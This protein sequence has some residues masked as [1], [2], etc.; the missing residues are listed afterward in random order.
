M[1]QKE[2]TP[3]NHFIFAA[4]IFFFYGLFSTSWAQWSKHAG[5]EYAGL[6]NSYSDAGG[7]EGAYDVS[8]DSAGNA[9]IVG[10]INSD[11]NIFGTNLVADGPWDSFVSKLDSSGNAVWTRH[12]YGS[13]Y[14]AKPSISIDHSSNVYVTGYFSGTA[15]IF[16]SSLTST[17]SYD[18]YLTKLDAS[19][20]AVWAKSF[21]GSNVEFPTAIVIDDSTN[22]YVTGSFA[23]SADFFGTT[24][25]STGSEDI[26]ISKLDSDG[27]EIWSKR[28][29]GPQLDRGHD[30]AVDSSGHVFI[31][32]FFST[33]ADVFG[34]TFV[35]GGPSGWYD[36]FVAQLD[37]NG[38]GVWAKQGGSDVDARDQA[39]GIDVD[40]NGNVY[41]IGRFQ[42]DAD[43][44]GET[45]SG[46][47][48]DNV[49]IVRLEPDGNIDW[50]KHWTNSSSTYGS[51]VQVSGTNVYVTGAFYGT[52]HADTQSTT[53]GG[54]LDIY[55]GVLNASNGNIRSL[56]SFG[57]S[58]FDSGE[59]IAVHENGTIYLVGRFKETMTAFGTELVTYG[60]YDVFISQIAVRPDDLTLV[61]YTP[62][63]TGMPSGTNTYLPGSLLT[64]SIIAPT[65]SGGTQYVCTGWILT[66]NEPGSGTGTQAVFTIT[67]ESILVWNWGTNYEL[68]VTSEA[69]GSVAGSGG[70]LPAGSS[71]QLTAQADTYYTFTNW[72][73]DVIGANIWSN[74]LVVMMDGPKVLNAHFE[75]VV[76]TNSHVPYWWLAT[77]GWTNDFETAQA[78]DQDGDGYWTWEEWIT[79][80]DPTNTASSFLLDG[81]L[82]NGQIELGWTGPVS[83]RVYT[84]ESSGNLK[85]GF[86]NIVTVLSNSPSCT[87]TIQAA[88][89]TTFYRITVEM[90]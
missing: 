1:T 2:F 74:P 16:G 51:D 56:D 87:W 78:E 88:E 35:A 17:G 73:G 22:L 15:T 12:A 86:T 67:N 60:C 50:I 57:G 85:I 43:I 83:G 65:A 81:V 46:V 66:G 21:G 39:G 52:L 8:V 18:G 32:G 80:T 82:E 25:V 72:T 10:L 34:T 89:K 20:N 9:Y 55:Y 4:A 49:F 53:S 63:G 64:N 26:F 3:F 6:C 42:Y 90:E 28:A 5:G 7:S 58:S 13:G 24:L 77:Y 47:N 11:A 23:G 59:A 45:L 40:E 69:H 61:V 30:V 19:G 84:L 31:T 62:H 48:R 70:W 76:T 75:A 41:V 27:Q 14:V 68:S 38:T 36:A 29:G 44:F 37:T 54:S 79:G 33:T 71:T